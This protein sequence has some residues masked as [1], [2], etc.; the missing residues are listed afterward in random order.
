VFLDRTY[1]IEGE[2]VIVKADV[3]YRQYK[4]TDR[5]MHTQLLVPSGLRNRVIKMAHEGIMSR[6]QV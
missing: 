2:R 6:H 1:K 5:I 3:L 4:H